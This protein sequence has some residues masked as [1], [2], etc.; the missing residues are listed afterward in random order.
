MAFECLTGQVPF[1]RETDIATAMAHIKDPPPSA[2]ALQ[3]DAA[4]RSRCRPRAGHGQGTRRS[5]PDLR[6]LPGRPAWCARA[7]GSYV[8]PVGRRTGRRRRWCRGRRRRDRR[9]AAG[10]RRRL[11]PSAAR[12]APAR[13]RPPA[14]R[15]V[16]RLR[17]SS[18]AR[19]RTSTRTRP[20]RRCWPRSRPILRRRAS[21]VHTWRCRVS[22]A[23]GHPLASL[24]V[25]PAGQLRRQP[26]RG[27]AL[28][29]LRHVHRQRRLHDQSA[30]SGIARRY[31][32]KGGDCATQTRVNGRWKLGDEDA[33]AIICYL[34][35]TTGD[36]ILWWS[37]KDASVLVKAVNQR[38]E[39]PR[40]TRYFDRVARF[41][42]P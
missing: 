21:A 22:S 37:Y 26:G 3:P 16:W 17:R 28:S 14:R 1:V 31:G 40:S 11:G 18:P 19:R 5:L 23:S 29:L 2:L 27:P 42:Q 35:P 4:G 39:R 7:D 36:A 34:D 30:I 10:R 32:T 15:R 33:G 8:A 38:G 20:R 9:G 12:P 13:C 41:I 6:R 25:H 24:T